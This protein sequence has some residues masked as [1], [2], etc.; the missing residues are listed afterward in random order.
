MILIVDQPQEGYYR[1]R[2]VR[3]G[4]FVPV[5]IWHGPPHDPE[6]GEELD[7]SPRWQALVNG[8]ERDAREIWNWCADKPISESEY[9]Y[10][11]AVKNWAETHAP[12]EPEANPYQRADARTAAPVGPPR[13]T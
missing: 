1:T 10:M 9:R 3:G 7:R 4:P 5:K 6:T 8:E 11:L 2:L 12:A 13:R